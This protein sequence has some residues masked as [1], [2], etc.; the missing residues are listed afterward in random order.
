M[1]EL[2]SVYRKEEGEG[3]KARHGMNLFCRESSA[4]NKGPRNNRK[5][6]NNIER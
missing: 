3:K 4:P 5:N 6:T 2:V 1:K